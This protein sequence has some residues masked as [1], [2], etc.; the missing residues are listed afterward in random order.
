MAAVD[1]DAGGTKLAAQFEALCVRHRL[2]FLRH[3]PDPALGKDWNEV[4]QRFERDYIRYLP[5]GREFGPERGR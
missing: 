1:A 2:V 4:L 5:A 3:S